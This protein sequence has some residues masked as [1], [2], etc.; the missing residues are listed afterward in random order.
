[1]TRNM[2]RSSRSMNVYLG[3]LNEKLVINNP[4]G[5]ER[6]D[7]HIPRSGCESHQDLKDLVSYIKGIVIV[8]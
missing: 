7:L 6:F 2:I 1:M 4:L 3:H 8:F 5:C